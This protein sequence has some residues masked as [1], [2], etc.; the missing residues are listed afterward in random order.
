MLEELVMVM[1]CW[2]PVPRSLADTFTMP[3][4]SMEKVTS[5][6]GTPRM[7]LR[8]PSRRKRPSSLFWDAI[9]RSPWSTCTSTAV[10]KLAAV[11]KI[12]LR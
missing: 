3:F 8:M 12:W 2:R 7:A 11:V 4:A 9:G 5:I 10:W 1:F 6:C